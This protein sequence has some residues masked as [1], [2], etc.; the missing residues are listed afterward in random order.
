MTEFDL[1]DLLRI[2][3]A[4]GNR[5]KNLRRLRLEV[6][7]NDRYAYELL[8]NLCEEIEGCKKLIK[9]VTNQYFQLI[10]HHNDH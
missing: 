5:L 7:E 6:Q 2:K 9:K 8:E 1:G 10:S 4:V 3:I